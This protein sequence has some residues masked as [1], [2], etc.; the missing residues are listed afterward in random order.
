MKFKNVNLFLVLLLLICLTVGAAS[1]V[2]DGNLT[3]DDG[4]NLDISDYSSELSCPSSDED[5]VTSS[6]H[7]ITNDN[8]NQYFDSEGNLIS[9]SVNSGDAITLDGSFSGVNFTFNK[10][11]NVDGTSSNH[12]KNCI[13]T[14]TSNASGSS[15]SNLKIENSLGFTYGIFL[16][17]ASDC[18]IQNCV[19]KNTGKSSY[20]I[21]LGNGANHNNVTGNDLATYGVTYGH[22]TRSTATMVVS[23]SHN[24]YIANNKV[25]CDDANGIYLSIYDGGPLKGGVSNFNTI[26]NNTI[27]YNVLPTSWSFGIQIMGGN[28]T[29]DS[30]RIIGAYRGISA[31][32][33]KYNQF[34][35]NDIIN[36][37]GADYANPNVE[38]G[39]EYAIVAT[40][41]SVVKD[42]RI[43]NAKLISS[44]SAIYAPANCLVENN[45]VEVVSS[46]RGIEAYG[47]NVVIRGNH[48]NTTTGSAIYHKDESV[49]L[50]VDSNIIDSGSA[51]G[52]LVEHYSRNQM[53]SSI[54]IIN[55]V[56]ST[57]NDYAI[58][59]S[60]ANKSSYLIDGNEVNKKN[61]K[62]PAGEIDTSRPIYKFDGVTYNITPENYNQYI[63]D[64]GGLS[65]DI[66]EGDTL[67]FTGS[68]SDKVIYVNN[69][70]KITGDNAVFYNST[71][72]VTSGNVWIENI[73]INNKN[74]NRLNAW[75]ILVYRS[76]GVTLFNN[77]ITVYDPN[78]AY[79]I[80]VLESEC[81]DVL[82]NTLY[83]S[84]SH[85]LTYTLLGLS[86]MDCRFEGNTIT[87]VGCGEIYGYEPEKCIDG[88]ESCLDGG[89]S[90]VDGGVSCIDGGESC[91]D[92]GE[93]CIDGGESCI[94]G[95]ESCIDGGESCIDGNENCLDGNSC[96]DGAHVVKEVFRTYGILLIYS[97]NNKV[98]N[99]YVYVTSL[100][101]ESYATT[102]AN[103]SSN[104]L[105]GIDIYFDS[106]NNIVSNNNVIVSGYDNYIYGM[107]V[108]GVVTGHDSS[109]SGSLNNQFIDNEVTLDGTYFATGFIAGD[110]SKNTTVSGN[111]FDITSNN[112]AY[113]ITLEMSKNSTIVKNTLTLNSDIIYGIQ[114]YSSDY[115]IMSQ[116]EIDAKGK[117]A[118]GIAISN[119]NRNTIVDNKIN[120]NGTGEEVTFKNY[121]SIEG[122]NA[123]LYLKSHSDNNLIDGNEITS[124]VGHAIMVDEVAKGNVITNNYLAS[125]EGMGSVAI[126]NI[127]NNTVKDNYGYYFEGTPSDVTVRYLE[128][129]TITFTTNDVAN[130]AVVK[131]YANGILLG[132]SV[133][134]NG[135]ASLTYAFG[136]NF[137]PGSY[138]LRAVVSKDN[139]KTDEFESYLTVNKGTLKVVVTDISVKDG[140]KANFKAVVTNALGETISGL[141][142][143]FYRNSISAT[144]YYGKAATNNNGVASAA[145]STPYGVKGTAVVAAVAGN[146]YYEDSQGSGKL[147]I[148]S[149]APVTM[150]VNT[151]VYQNGVLVTLKDNNGFAVSN[152]YVTIKIGSKSYSVRTSSS[153]TITLPKT[154]AGTYNVVV[155]YGGHSLYEPAKVSKKITVKPIITGN[156]N[157]SVYYYNTVTYKVRILDTAGKAVGAGKV[158][159]FKVGGKTY[160]VKTDKNGYASKSV[161]F[162]PGT[163]T[164]TASYGGYSVS[165][166]IVFKPIIISQDLTTKKSSVTKFSVKLVDKNGNIMKNKKIVFKI[167][168]RTYVAYTSK[169]GYAT[170]N[171][172]MVLNPGTYTITSSYNSFKVTNKIIVKR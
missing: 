171:I 132:Q 57:S 108:I 117:Q 18:V 87:A 40:T 45:N 112:I 54:S 30:N 86:V 64:N 145:L 121:D 50:V 48:V 12:F 53:P 111:T 166:K 141:T 157:Y 93:S 109:E 164:I 52:I 125:E 58:D 116:N 154:N 89:E 160:S 159:T 169:Y 9:A 156:K 96:F 14:L 129:A 32:S 155:T 130:G 144:N 77:S 123:G 137:I 90:C 126:D 46:G 10:Q 29:V 38:V 51:I 114:G 140:L 74:T 85:Y 98:S 27:K 34:I 83:S 79:A 147:N 8:Y 124:N 63:N 3:D 69:G 56:V 97:S 92:G 47:S 81:V 65:S 55:N 59:A 68:F 23:G 73:K 118:Y 103:G 162:N 110:G 102:G 49:G 33:G 78:A 67:Y 42:N 70:I 161:K 104:S 6:S 41:D 82:N 113:G 158:V 60:Q 66:K 120:A 7:I 43:I 128:S 22:G 31:S 72:K 143:E 165:N 100:L 135:A 71:F 142:V 170:A 107:G 62:T 11:V 115:N 39:G 80:Y 36:C 105:V 76:V 44:G 2:E 61:I 168:G 13:F 127:V 91:I 4:T 148:L 172:N 26:Y 146:D 95:G 119:S 21:C 16:N 19:I 151:N 15:I 152:H 75:G 1:A 35:N 149:K 25:T 167:K 88:N 122:G 94:D 138:I 136:K 101:N 37:T 84:A 106:N 134:S 150:T 24:N 153:G 17:G 131:F 20:A 139:F 133:V 163:Y 99:N 28:N 5:I